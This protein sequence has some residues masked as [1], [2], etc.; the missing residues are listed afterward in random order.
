MSITDLERFMDYIKEKDIMFEM[1]VDYGETNWYILMTVAQ[2]FFD[3]KDYSMTY[4]IFENEFDQNLDI[5][6][7]WH[8][9]DM[10]SRGIRFFHHDE[11][12]STL[13]KQL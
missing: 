1:L 9:K 6:T 10:E 5:I 4:D 12:V 7:S 3:Q 11:I 13:L 8:R 2:Q